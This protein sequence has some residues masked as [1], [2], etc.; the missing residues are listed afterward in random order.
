[1]TAV[2]IGSIQ[3]RRGIV[4]GATAWWSASNPLNSISGGTNV[5]TYADMSGNSRDITQ[6]TAGKR[7]AYG[8]GAGD[9]FDGVDDVLSG[10][11]WGTLIDANKF[12]IFVAFTPIAWSTTSSLGSAHLNHGIVGEGG[13]YL[14][15]SMRNV[16]GSELM[17][18]IADGVYKGVTLP[19]TLG[20]K[21][22]VCFRYDG[23]TIY[24][25]VNGGAEVSAACGNVAA[26][27]LA[28]V[29]RLGQGFSVYANAQ[30]LEAIT[31]D[32]LLS[33]SDI[34]TNVAYIRGKWGF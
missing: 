16:A 30:T 31:Y 3:A 9:T 18:W 34:A 6:G 4:A 20:A 5:V 1:M 2:P 27:G 29:V 7:P 11:T 33:A 8:S 32:A 14:G 23:T 17:C 19:G 21:C 10:T 15:L 25:S 12:A 22:V 26:P 13:A 24:G 28:Q